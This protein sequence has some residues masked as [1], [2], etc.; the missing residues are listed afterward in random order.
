MKTCFISRFGAYGDLMHCSH[1]PQ[2]IKEHYKIDRIDFET[3]Y[4]G[5]Q[6]LQGNPYIDNLIFVDVAKLTQNRMIKNWEHCKENYDLFFNLVYSIER[7]YC[8]LENCNKYYRSTAWRREHL[9]RMNYYDVMTQFVGLPE[10][11]FGTR[12]KLY[13]K[14]EEHL[15]AKQAVQDLKTKYNAGW[16]ILVCLSGSS[17]HKRFQQA[18]SISRKILEKYPDALVILTGDES[19]LFQVFKGDR[20]VCKVDR[21]NF[22]TVALMCAYFDLVISPETGLACVAHSWDTPTL[23]L[24]TAASWDNH[25]KYAKNAYWVQSPV[26]CS[27]CHKGPYQYYGCPRKD[28]LPACVFFNEDEI[29]SKVEEAHNEYKAKIR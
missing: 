16:A 25:I 18:E 9:G 4:Q 13:Y 20:I 1:L 23:Q 14:P 26:V 15:K 28:D 22:R 12:G 7:E 6:I 10:S 17:M 2:L 5:Y 29:M 24:L 11:Y 8:C 21:W 27:P 19:C 3:G